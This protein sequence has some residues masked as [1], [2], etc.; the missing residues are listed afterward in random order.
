MDVALLI[1]IPEELKEWL[2]REAALHDRSLSKEAK[3]M[4]EQ[5]H[6]RRKEEELYG[7]SGDPCTHS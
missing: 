3:R 2:A 5:E 7:L 4:L 1:R 6:Q